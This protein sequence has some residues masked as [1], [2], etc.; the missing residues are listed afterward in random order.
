MLIRISFRGAKN[1]FIRD[2]NDKQQITDP[3]A[4]SYTREFLSSQLIY[5][6]IILPY[7]DVIKR[8]KVY[9]SEQHSLVIIDTFSCQDDDIF[10]ELCGKN[11]TPQ[12]NEVFRKGFL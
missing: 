10:S 7:L 11:N 2:V 8:E 3:L 6:E 1:F 9:R 5:S 12:T 4:V